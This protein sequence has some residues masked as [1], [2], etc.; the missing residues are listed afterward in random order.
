MQNVDIVDIVDSTHRFWKRG[1]HKLRKK[2][3]VNASKVFHI[4]QKRYP[5]ILFIIK[6]KEAVDIV[7]N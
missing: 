2:G 6:E 7:D 1:V 5:Q 3:G 4:W